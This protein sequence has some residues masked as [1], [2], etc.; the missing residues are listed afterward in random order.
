V[1]GER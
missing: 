1:G